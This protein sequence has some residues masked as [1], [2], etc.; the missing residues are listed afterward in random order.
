MGLWLS[1]VLVLA[2][3]PGRDG[4]ASGSEARSGVMLA[5]TFA[6][7]VCSVEVGRGVAV[8]V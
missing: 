1:L 5:F 4:L 8:G 3:A 6:V 7:L 2:L